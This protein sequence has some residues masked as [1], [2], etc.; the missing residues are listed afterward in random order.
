MHCQVADTLLCRRAHNVSYGFPS[1]ADESPA[2]EASYA[3]IQSLF[4][5]EMFA[6]F[7]SAIARRLI[8]GGSGDDAV[9]AACNLQP[10]T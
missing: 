7:D 1:W 9:C 6:E 2:G 5:Y 8:G 3:H 4:S 10:D